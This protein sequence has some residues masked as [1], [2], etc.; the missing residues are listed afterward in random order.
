MTSHNNTLR[1]INSIQ[2][3]YFALKSM[4]SLFF[5]FS[6]KLSLSLS[7]E[8]TALKMDVKKKTL[9]FPPMTFLIQTYYEK[10]K[11]FLTMKYEILSKAS[12]CEIE[13]PISMIHIQTD[14]VLHLL[15][16][17]ESANMFSNF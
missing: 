16:I 13:F 3:E 4:F 12:S 6:I 15:G 5:V 2:S 17:G 8:I 9:F 1:T 11:E 7:L 14:V 10:K